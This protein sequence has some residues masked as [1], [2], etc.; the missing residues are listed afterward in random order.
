MAGLLA[1]CLVA[2]SAEIENSAAVEAGIE[3]YA[4]ATIVKEVKGVKAPFI[5]GDYAIFTAEDTSRYVGIA[6][7][8]ENYRTI[9]VFNKR[10]SYDENGDPQSS[11][12]I[13]LLKL[14][15]N[16]TKITYR[17]IIDGLWTSDS[18][19]ANK[20]FDTNTGTWFSYLDV[21]RPYMDETAVTDSHVV[22]FVYEGN[23]GQRIRLAGNFTNWDSFI[24]Y[25]NETTPGHYE[26]SV[27]LPTGTWYYCFYSGMDRITDPKNTDRVYTRDGRIA[28]VITVN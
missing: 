27:P 28:S 7:D 10:V 14:P 24:Y 26:L 13:Y 15:V 8:F 5:S 4:R 17:L 19:N 18:H 22:R 12:L 2:A 1:F 16:C 20:Y 25:L 6:F 23:A 21:N 3:E 9:H 11:M